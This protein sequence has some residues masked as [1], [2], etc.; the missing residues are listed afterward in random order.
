MQTFMQGKMVSF[1]R[2]ST[3]GG[4]RMYYAK[5]VCGRVRQVRDVSC[6]LTQR[7]ETGFVLS[8][9]DDGDMPLLFS[10]QHWRERASCP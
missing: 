8:G 2:V 10:G 1:F 7:V 6:S 5:W 3:L 9:Y 4:P